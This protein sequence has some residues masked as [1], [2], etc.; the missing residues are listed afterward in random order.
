MYLGE[1]K[2]YAHKNLF[3]MF[4]AALVIRASKWK[5]PKFPSLDKYINKTSYPS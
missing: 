1:L 5:W 3:T 4:T 2:I